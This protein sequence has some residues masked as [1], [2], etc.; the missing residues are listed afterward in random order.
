MTGATA[1]TGANTDNRWWH[2]MTAGNGGP[3]RGR[4]G[5]RAMPC[6]SRTEHATIVGAAEAAWNTMN[7]C[8]LPTRH[9]TSHINI[10][11]NAN[12][13][14]RMSMHRTTT[15]ARRQHINSKHGTIRNMAG[16]GR[17]PGPPP[18]G[19]GLPAVC[20]KGMLLRR[21]LRL[22]LLWCG[23]RRLSNWSTQSLMKTG[24][25]PLCLDAGGRSPGG[26][27]RPRPPAAVREEHHL[28][29]RGK[30]NPARSPSL[31]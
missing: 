9:G 25:G 22:R 8:A 12:N 17:T 30:G 24:P 29:K 23:G 15:S 2:D 16:H 5:T 21:L 31:P 4:T 13:P 10:N 6:G 18:S 11:N 28:V 26:H 14:I 7:P 1:A 19:R 3:L 27:S 20:T